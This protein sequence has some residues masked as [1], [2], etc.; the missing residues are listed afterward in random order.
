MKILCNDGNVREFSKAICD[1]DYMPDGT[2]ANLPSHGID[3]TCIN[4]G[5]AFGVHSSKYLKPRFKAHICTSGPDWQ[6]QAA[7]TLGR[8]GGK[9]RA[10]SMTKKERSEASRKAA[11]A[12]WAKP[13]GAN[14]SKGI[15]K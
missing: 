3:A 15:K 4:C 1:G 7:V 10:A 2:R 14:I 5:Y 13:R 8:K 11:T 12:R 6:N 9:A